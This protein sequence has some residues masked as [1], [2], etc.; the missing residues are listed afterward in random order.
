[1]DAFQQLLLRHDLGAI[2][3]VLFGY[4]L[5]LLLYCAW[6]ALAFVEL[7]RAPGSTGRVAAWS[8]VVLGIPFLGAA[9]FLYRMGGGLS[10]PVRVVVLL[11][12][13]A[14]VVI[15]YLLTPFVFH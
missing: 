1:M 11:A 12:G 4:F 14:L 9:L 15:G 13:P 3:T 2:V 5:P 10:G 6:S 7:A 8:L